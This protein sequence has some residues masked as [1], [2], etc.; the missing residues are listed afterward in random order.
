MVVL[1]DIDGTLIDSGGSGTRSWRAAFEKLYGVSADIGDFSAAGQTD[2]EVARA[3]FRGALNR[4]P[5][6]DELGNL[7]AQ[8]LLSLAD[9]IWT[10]AGYRVLAGAER[11]LVRLGEAGAMIG[12]VSGALEGAARTKL[13]PANLNRYFVFGA[14]GT[15]SPDRAEL[16]RL[17]I[18]KATLLQPELTPAG[19]YVVGDTPLDISAA[20]AAGAVSVGVASGAYSIDQ[21][22][23]AGADHVMGSLEDAFPGQLEHRRSDT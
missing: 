17:A 10:S 20:R 14:Y 8:Y 3:T 7:Y 16:T 22:S 18:N 9:D 23:A 11:T 1:F 15:D 19:V 2:P 21:L 4:D 5:E 12:L 6:Q 13:T